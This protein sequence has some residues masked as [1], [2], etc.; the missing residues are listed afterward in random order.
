LRR[1]G[2]Q[3][4]AQ[5]RCHWFLDVLP[6]RAS[7]S[8]AI[9]FLAQSWGLP[10]E[11]VLVIAS[12]QG[13]GELLGGLPATVV[14]ADHDPCLISQRQQTRVFLSNRSSIAAVLDGLEHYKFKTLSK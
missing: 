9:R 7:R 5:L 6:Q 8:E 14:P 11:Q 1:H 2:L 10:L 12:Q 4:E 13:D 3:A